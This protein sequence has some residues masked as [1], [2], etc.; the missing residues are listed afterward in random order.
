MEPVFQRYDAMVK[1]C[2][3]DRE[4]LGRSTW[5]F[6]HTMAAYFPKKPSASHQSDMKQFLNLFSKFYPCKECAD[7]LQVEISKNPPRTSSQ[8]ELSQWMCQI[9]NNVNKKLG[10]PLFDCT[11]VDER[12]L[13][14]WKDG[15]CD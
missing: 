13:H 9:H 12:W 3:L 6:L 2:P 10:K 5:A 14:G 11:S 7:D 4:E 1:E 15:S 8:Y